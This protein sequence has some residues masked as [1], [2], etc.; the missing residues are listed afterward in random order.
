MSAGQDWRRENI[1]PLRTGFLVRGSWTKADVWTA[2]IP[3]GAKV[4][5]KD[6]RAKSFLVRYWGW[7]QIAREARFLEQL[8]PLGFVPRLFGRLDRFSLAMEY[9]EGIPLFLFEDGP[10]CRPFLEALRR[11]LDQVQALGVIHNDLRGRENVF[12]AEGGRVVIL[13]WAGAVQI[14]PGGLAHRLFWKVWKAVDDSAFLK[15]KDMKDP[16]SLSASERQFLRRF[17]R[18]RRLWPFNRKG[19][20]WTRDM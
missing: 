12:L 6:F 19:L 2:E 8:G 1:E 11:A 15:W 4:V 16:E 10:A 13:D 18:W 9:L 14:K 3:D 17:R 5:V 7:L 20:G